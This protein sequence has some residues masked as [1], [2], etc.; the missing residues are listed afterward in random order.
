MV[1]FLLSR[2][3]L[4][5]LERYHGCRI[6][7]CGHRVRQLF[8]HHEDLLH[9]NSLPWCL[10]YCT[11]HLDQLHRAAWLLVN[12]DTLTCFTIQEFDDEELT[13]SKFQE[14]DDEELTSSKIQEF[15]DKRADVCSA[16]ANDA[17]VCRVGV[18]V[19]QLLKR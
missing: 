7:L 17:R 6:S 19:S 16:W 8:P 5:I 15:A 14:V 18:T 12:M 4:V 13:S 10:V 3:S 11:V 1:A 9:A 2:G